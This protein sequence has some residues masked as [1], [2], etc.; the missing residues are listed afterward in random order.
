MIGSVTWPIGSCA[1]APAIIGPLP[2]ILG[3][4]EVGPEQDEGGND[5]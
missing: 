3:Q 5:P 4:R 1:G 2:L